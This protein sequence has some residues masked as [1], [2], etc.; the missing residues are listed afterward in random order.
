ME[1]SRSPPKTVFGPLVTS[2]RFAA[3]GKIAKLG[4]RHRPTSR[5]IRMFDGRNRPPTTAS[6]D[7]AGDGRAPSRDQQRIVGTRGRIGG[8]AGGWLGGYGWVALLVL[9]AGCVNILSAAQHA[10][11]ASWAELRG[12]VVDEITSASVIICLLPLI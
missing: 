12:P 5:R 1:R 9:A 7:S 8:I 4:G 10:G 11:S 6:V 2:R 3:G